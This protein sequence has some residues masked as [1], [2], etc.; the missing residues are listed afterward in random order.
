MKTKLLLVAMVSTLFCNQADANTI[1]RFMGS[2]QSQQNYVAIHRASE[3]AQEAKTI[4]VVAL[5]VAVIA[6]IVAIKASENNPGQIHILS[7]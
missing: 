5:S 6:T 7:F 1:R 2:T 3:K 4:A